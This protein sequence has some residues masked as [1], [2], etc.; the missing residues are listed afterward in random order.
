MWDTH[1]SYPFQLP[2]VD[3]RQD[4]GKYVWTKEEIEEWKSN[5]AVFLL[6]AN[7]IMLKGF[8]KKEERKS[9]WKELLV[10]QVETV[11]CVAI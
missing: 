10:V 8:A 1:P 5:H 6:G 11:I 7:M 3:L 2:E 9:L 4:P